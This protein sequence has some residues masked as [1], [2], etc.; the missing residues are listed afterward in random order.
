PPL[1]G[2]EDIRMLLTR[3]STLE[4]VMRRAVLAEPGITHLPGRAVVGVDGT[5]GAVRGAH[6]DD[7]SVLAG[8]VV[9]ATGRR[10]DVGAWLAPVGVQV[11]EELVQ[12]QLIY[13]TRWYSAPDFA[14]PSSGLLKD[15][16][17]MSYLVVP[18]DG[19]TLAVAVGLPPEDRE[20]RACMLDDHGFDRVAALLP[21]LGEGLAEA[22]ARPLRSSQP[23]AG[24]VN[25]LRRFADRSGEPLVTGFHA[26]G[27]AHT[28]TNPAY[29]RG[30]SLALVG[31]SL[32]A[33]AVA[34]HP[35]DPAARTRAYEA[36]CAAEIEPWFHSSVMM[37]QARLSM[38]RGAAA[39][40]EGQPDIFRVLLAAGAGLI[41][42]P[43]VIGGFAR[44]LHL[45]VTPERLFGDAEFTARFLQ[46]MSNPP[47]LPS[48]QTGPTREELLRAASAAA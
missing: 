30:C 41:D 47:E 1:E 38:R 14:M 35:G 22:S 5:G 29:G 15:L 11:Q 23:M 42:D 13:I 43:V 27:D 4:W 20:L 21:G 32:L 26:V 39:P 36:A 48:G 17:Y 25:R 40:A 12:S 44:L 37:D 33:D 46:L 9:A 3:R 7:G 18:A 34:A 10:T 24:L 45:L 8:T 28:C 2:L 6:L 19:G 31:A 16:G